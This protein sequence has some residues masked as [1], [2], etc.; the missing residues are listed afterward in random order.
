ML[1]YILEI[2]R[3]MRMHFA[4]GNLEKNSFMESLLQHKKEA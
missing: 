3:H 1:E 4:L 2:L